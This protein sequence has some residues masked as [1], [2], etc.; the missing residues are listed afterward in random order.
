MLEQL[1]QFVNQ[2]GW[3]V[4]V[5]LL[6][7]FSISQISYGIAQYRVTKKTE[8]NTIQGMVTNLTSSYNELMIKYENLRLEMSEMVNGKIEDD[9]RI[10]NLETLVEVL[11]RDIHDL[12][13]IKE[14]LQDR[15]DVAIQ[16]LSDC[17]RNRLE[18][19]V[20]IS[21]LR[22]ELKEKNL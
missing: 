6:L 16:K 3:Q 2:F 4:T 22:K 21:E 13:I 1:M 10:A 17:E 15:Y 12:K 7:S 5:F 8:S 9:K 20:L 19:E 14:D 18:A 11:Q